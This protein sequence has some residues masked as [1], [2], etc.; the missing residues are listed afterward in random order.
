VPAHA[1]V[2]LQLQ[3]GLCALASK[4]TTSKGVRSDAMHVQ[5]KQCCQ[6]KNSLLGNTCACDHRHTCQVR[7]E[8]SSHGCSV[9][10]PTQASP[11]TH[12]PIAPDHTLKAPCE[13]GVRRDCN[14]LPSYHAATGTQARSTPQIS[15]HGC[16]VGLP[17][18]GSLQTPFTHQPMAPDHIS[19]EH[20]WMW[21]RA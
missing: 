21:S 8:P 3:R 10:L 15:S 6:V 14:H 9:A 12:Q 5:W 20:P 18:Q 4:S 16:C 19:M 7:H 17:T 13:W 11:Q 2:R 1:L